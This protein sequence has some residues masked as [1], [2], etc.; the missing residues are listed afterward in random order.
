MG[1]CGMG[2]A[3]IGLGFGAES[4]RTGTRENGSMDLT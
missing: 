4:K 3:W 2:L 1:W